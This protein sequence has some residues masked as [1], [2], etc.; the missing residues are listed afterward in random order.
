LGVQFSLLSLLTL[1]AV[2]AVALAFVRTLNLP[3]S[4]Q[5][6]FAGGAIL[7]ATYLLLRGVALCRKSF[8]LRRQVAD[9][10]RELEAWLEDKASGSKK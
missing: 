6:I 9:R 5:L 7:M 2:S 1:T 3:P 10:R 4:V 8:R